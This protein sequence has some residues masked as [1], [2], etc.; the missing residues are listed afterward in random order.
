MTEIK[1]EKVICDA[2]SDIKL[3]RIVIIKTDLISSLQKPVLHDPPN[4]IEGSKEVKS[5]SVITGYV[6][7]Y[8]SGS[9]FQKK[10]YKQNFSITMSDGMIVFRSNPEND[11]EIAYDKIQMIFEVEGGRVIYKRADNDE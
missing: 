4:P 7:P 5:Y 6:A 10:Y 3:D 2:L 8:E 9:G 11:N 1:L